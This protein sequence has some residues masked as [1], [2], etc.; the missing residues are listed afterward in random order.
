MDGTAFNC[1]QFKYR[2]ALSGWHSPLGKLAFL[3]VFEMCVTCSE[4]KMHWGLKMSVT[5]NGVKNS[6]SVMLTAC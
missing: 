2:L 3:L 5:S 4:F 6:I 1:Q